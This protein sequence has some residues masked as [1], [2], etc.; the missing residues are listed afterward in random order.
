MSGNCDQGSCVALA[1]EL[2]IIVQG[3]TVRCTLCSVAPRLLETTEFPIRRD[4]L[5]GDQR[6]QSGQPVKIVGLAMV[7]LVGCMI[8]VW[9]PYVNG[10]PCPMISKPNS[11]ACAQR[12][13]P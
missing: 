12:T 13:K 10:V 1:H 6:F 5:G 4:A 7:G 2:R 3:R 8:N 9:S 11:S